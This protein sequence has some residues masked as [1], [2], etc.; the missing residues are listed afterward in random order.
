MLHPDGRF[1]IQAAAELYEA[2]LKQI[3]QNDY[4]NFTRRAAVSPVE[5]LR[6][7]PG[8]WYRSR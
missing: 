3:E 4:N 2:I 5:K 7:L 8:I 1:A 6:R